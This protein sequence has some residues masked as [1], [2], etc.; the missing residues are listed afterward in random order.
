MRSEKHQ[1]F[2]DLAP[3]QTQ[4]REE[5]VEKK[6]LFFSF[7]LNFGFGSP[8]CILLLRNGASWTP[9]WDNERVKILKKR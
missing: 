8:W 2:R 7:P 3:P 4:D 1:C 9:C 6:T 5:L